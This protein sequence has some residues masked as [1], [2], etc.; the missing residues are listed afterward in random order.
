MILGFRVVDRIKQDC[1]ASAETIRVCLKGDKKSFLVLWLGIVLIWIPVFLAV[2]PGIYSYDAS[3]QILEIYG[4]WGLDS[5]HP[6]IHTL[7]LNGCL[8]LGDLIFNDFNTG[9]AIYSIIQGSV[10]A[11]AFANVCN[12]MLRYHVSKIIVVCAFIWF[13]LNP[14][15][16]IFVFITTKDVLFTAFFI[17]C[18]TLTVEMFL[19]QTFFDTKSKLLE[20]AIATVLMILFRN[21][22]KYIF[23]LFIAAGAICFKTARKKFLTVCIVSIIAAQI[24]T[25]PVSSMMGVKKGSIREALSVPIQQL[26]RVY[27]LH[28]GYYTEEDLRLLYGLIPIEGW[29]AYEPEI[30]DPV[31]SG[32]NNEFWAENKTEL[33][34]LW[35]RTGKD[36]FMLYVESFL[37]G[38]YGYWYVDSSPRVQAYI[39]FD[40]FF[41]QPEFNILNITRESKF[42]SYE[43]Y[44]RRISFELVYEKVPIIAV[45]L[46]QGFPF[47]CILFLAGYT[48]YRKQ[49][50][51][52]L[53]LIWFFGLW[54][55][56]L[57]GPVICVRYAY[58]L[59][60]A[61]PTLGMVIY[62]HEQPKPD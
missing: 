34:K 7:F 22:G 2:Y 36:N 46:N 10:L 52:L 24:I 57:L 31:K 58:P 6:V 59:M 16:Q 33:M 41:M 5:H 43:E 61:I 11:A 45:V 14:I 25:G 40:G 44:L 32:F 9:I 27:N 15:N 49:Y 51:A 17:W 42:S 19:E 62:V 37:Y 8:Y 23:L 4:G 20:F 56:I 39:W 35:L 28:P 50:Q 38:A 13:T 29:T 3:I 48:I 60:A 1:H 21:Q 54:G 12:K 55:T 26:A 47:W 18:I 53:V 30:S